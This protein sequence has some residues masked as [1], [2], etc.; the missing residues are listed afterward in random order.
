[1][2][3]YRYFGRGGS[4]QAPYDKGRAATH[5]VGHWLKL[6]HIWGDAQCGDDYVNDTP[7]QTR[8]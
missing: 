4:A 6:R 1:V 3:D 7:V 8:A 2:I 5:E